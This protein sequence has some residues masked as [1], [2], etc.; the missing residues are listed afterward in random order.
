MRRSF[1][2]ECTRAAE[3]APLVQAHVG[4]SSISVS[5][6]H[7]ALEDLVENHKEHRKNVEV[8]LTIATKEIDKMSYAFP[9]RKPRWCAQLLAQV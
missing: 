6:L 7:D 4:D 3:L 2:R 9:G 1:S 5:V 8:L